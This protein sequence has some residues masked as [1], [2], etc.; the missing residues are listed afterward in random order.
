MN[1]YQLTIQ[2]DNGEIITRT[3]SSYESARSQMNYY[4]KKFNKIQVGAAGKITKA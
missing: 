4:L 1:T 3:Y 2:A